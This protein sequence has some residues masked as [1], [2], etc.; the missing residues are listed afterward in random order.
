MGEEDQLRLETHSNLT[1]QTSK[2]ITTLRSVNQHSLEVSEHTDFVILDLRDEVE[3]EK[4]RIKEGNT[5]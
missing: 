1:S 5:N 3:Y 2:T 4:Y